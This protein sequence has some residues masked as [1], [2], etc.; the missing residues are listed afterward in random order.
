[1]NNLLKDKYIVITGA[2]GDIGLSCCETFYN[3]GANLI[4]LYNKNRRKI[5]NFKKNKKIF[6]HT[7]AILLMKK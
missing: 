6:I 4:L 3:Q 1:M 5:L 7:V 2:S